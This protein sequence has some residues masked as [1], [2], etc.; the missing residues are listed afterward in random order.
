MNRS[1]KNQYDH[2]KHQYSCTSNI[3]ITYI[4]SK[5]TKS[6]ELITIGISVTGC[7]VNAKPYKKEASNHCGPL[8]G[9]QATKTL[10]NTL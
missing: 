1:I 5:S 6:L 10:K 4:N 7:F 8:N 9:D 3:L 2:D